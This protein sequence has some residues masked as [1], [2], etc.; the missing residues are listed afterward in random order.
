[1]ELSEYEKLS[2]KRLSERILEGKWSDEGLVKLI[3]RA[4]DYL[5]LKTVPDYSKAKGIS[6]V[7]A[8]KDTCYRKNIT[9][10]NTKFVI[11]ND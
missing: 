5:N 3:E 10:L 1:M 4:G 6:D 9:I 8:R 11:D 2:I 7:A